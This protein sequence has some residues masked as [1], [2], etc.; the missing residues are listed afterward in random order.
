M[1][2]QTLE[3][4]HA[5]GIGRRRSALRPK[6]LEDRSVESA[7]GVF[8]IEPL[9]CAGD[10][11]HGKRPGLTTSDREWQLDLERENRELMRGFRPRTDDVL[12]PGYPRSGSYPAHGA[13]FVG[14]V[15]GIV[16]GSSP[17]RNEE[18]V[19]RRGRISRVGHEFALVLADRH[20]TS[21]GPSARWRGAHRGALAFH[22]HAGLA[23]NP[24]RTDARIRS[25]VLEALQRT[26]AG[27]RG[28]AEEPRAALTRCRAG[29][30][31]DARTTGRVTL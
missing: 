13:D 14:A 19:L 24:R 8:S 18:R 12:T 3:A 21:L 31:A 25:A 1:D 10:L 27:R 23:G 16:S 6:R 26:E 29:L 4:E 5:H 28:R 11:D 2:L 20:S 22:D 17:S 9:P 30:G 7:R 15:A